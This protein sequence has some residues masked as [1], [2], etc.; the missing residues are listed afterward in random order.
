[1]Q[2]WGVSWARSIHNKQRSL[3]LILMAMSIHQKILSRSLKCVQG[4][5][6]FLVSIKIF[7]KQILNM[8]RCVHAPDTMLQKMV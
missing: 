1:M 7:N 8:Y 5:F 4:F 3:G 6:Y 2:N